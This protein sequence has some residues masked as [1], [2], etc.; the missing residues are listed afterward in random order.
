VVGETANAP[1]RNGAELLVQLLAAQ[2][3]EYIFL[4]P[5]TDTAPLQETLVALRAEGHRV[6]EIVPCLF[7]NVALAAALGYFAVTRRPQVVVV[8]VDVGT[9]NLGANLH[10]AQR[11]QGG[12]VIL[13]GRA[14][15][16]VDGEVPGG[17]DRAIHWQQDQLDQTGIVRNYVK[18]SHELGRT[19][20]LH[21][22]VPRAF[23]VAAAEPSGPVY[24]TVAREVLM[25]RMARDLP[26]TPARCPTPATPAPDPRAVETLAAWL[27]AAEAPLAI[28][29]TLGRHPEAVAELVA[30]AEF[31]GLPVADTRGPVNF[32]SS[33]PLYLGL[34]SRQ[35]LEASDCVLLLDVDVP[36][37]PRVAGDASGAR[38]AQ[39]D[40]DPVKASIPQWGF[41]VDLSI[42]ADTAKALP[43]L[44]VALERLATPGTRAR[45]DRR[46]AAIATRR[47][48]REQQLEAAVQRG[49]SQRPMDV[50]W[51]AAALARVIP[52]EAVVLE[53]A[54]TSAEAIRRHLRRDKPGTLLGSG[55][56]GL[57]WALGAAV[58]AKLAQPDRDVVALCGDGAFIF[59]SPIAALWAAHHMRTPCLTVIIDNRGYR[60]SKEP[61]V[62]L[63]PD[64]VSVRTD[65]FPGVRFTNPPDYALLAR[66]CHAHGERVEDP[67]ELPAALERALRAARGGT[68][69]VV[70]VVVTPI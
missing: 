41:P 32:P 70:D 37:V 20:T 47:D 65:E 61:V 19:D 27:A 60:A 29:G 51:V 31:L 21:Q 42:Q 3:V 28:V 58:G 18:W 10:N 13:A 2:G 39:I 34:E 52:S 4:N 17:R 5:G 23:Q 50:E 63:F 30:L 22:L 59:G 48:E 16:T 40:I 24:L 35:W 26:G 62:S 25:E 11:G 7:E 46:R 36:W 53:E 6:P 9:Q 1:A 57:G 68:S 15:Y 66:A 14:P 45:W 49:R 54:T 44:R 12:V 64:G 38:I 67:D 56:P 8:H 33:H 55:G 43:Q 69:A